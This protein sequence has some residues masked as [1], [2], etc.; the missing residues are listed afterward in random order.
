MERGSPVW[1]F[2]ASGNE[3]V[4]FSAIPLIGPGPLTVKF[5]NL[6]T[7]PQFDTYAWDFGDGETSTDVNP[8][9]VY[10]S[11]SVSGYNVQLIASHEASLASSASKAGY[12][13]ASIPSVTSA[14]TFTTSSNVA[15]FTVSFVN[16]SVNTSQT[17][18]TNY[19]WSFT[20]NNGT[21]AT[22]SSSTSISPSAISVDSGSFTASLAATGSYGIAS[23]YTQ[24]FIA[25]VPSLNIS[26]IVASSSIYSPSLVTLT[27][28][29][30][31]NGAGTIS[32]LW[33][34]GEWAEGGGEYTLPTITTWAN[35][36]YDTRSGVAATDGKFT[37][38]LQITE[39]LYGIKAFYTQSFALL[40][41]TI[42]PSFTVDSS[43]VEAPSIVTLTN[44]SIDNGA[45][46]FTGTWKFG[47]YSEAGAE[48]YLPYSSPIESRTYDTRSDASGTTIG[49]FTASL[50]LTGSNYG[51]MAFV[52]QSFYIT[53]SL[54]YVG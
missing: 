41:P 18:T 19:L 15:P 49:Q 42:I 52:T 10:Q 24:S 8:T 3:I 12:I 9:H 37:A 7:T 34:S 45:G 47:E 11:G 21:T 22:T 5:T 35:R 36:L 53:A 28:T 39:S 50:G 2:W 25:P 4:N 27:P 48:W 23:I 17:P 43:S 16:T 1:D 40:F 26:F 29:V 6:T 32:G 51:V 31:Y 30:T 54:P 33:G 46:T 44:T 38:S 20:Y 14:F 13:S